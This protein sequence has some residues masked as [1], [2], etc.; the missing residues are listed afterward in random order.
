[1]YF[2]HVKLLVPKQSCELLDIS[3]VALQILIMILGVHK[4]VLVRD[5]PKVFLAKSKLF[6]M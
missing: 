5:I 1:M 3:T 4:N 2:I 6:G